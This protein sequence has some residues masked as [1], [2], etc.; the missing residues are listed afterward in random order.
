M[1]LAGMLLF[2]AVAADGPGQKGQAGPPLPAV[3]FNEVHYHPARDADAEEEFIELH[4][5]TDGEVDLQGWEI[6]GGVRFR[7]DRGVGPTSL[8]PRGYLV[9]ARR[10]AGLSRV[11]GLSDS[12]IAGPYTGRLS[13]HRERLILVDAGGKEVESFEYSQDGVWPARADG[14]GSSLQRISSEAPAALP[15]NWTVGLG[16]NSPRR[17]ERVVFENG[18]RV[19]WFENQT[20]EDPG[21]AGGRP[22]HAPD[23]D[24]EKNGFRDGQLAVGFDISNRG[25]QR[26]INTD[27]TPARGLHSILI[28]IP[29]EAP[30][31]LQGE[32]LP[33]LYLDWDDGFVAW[34]NGVEIARRG[35]KL[36][37]G[38]P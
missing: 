38:T 23:F 21:F 22:W 32:D 5:R 6:R 9:V 30:R 31:E 26:W 10:P 11:T 19:R 1:G 34:L 25:Q 18:V 35:M 24:D 2:L 15:Q 14:L 4:N 37:A 8:R 29:F 13:N 28:R 12:S 20:G 16:E 36:P 3:I 27:A 17:E 33:V 7:F